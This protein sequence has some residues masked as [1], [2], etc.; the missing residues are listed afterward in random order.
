MSRIT[1]LDPTS[2]SGYVRELLDGVQKGLGVTPNLFRTA[3]RS[4]ATLEGLVALFGAAGRGKLGAKYR[5]AIALTV[6]ELDRCDYCLSA[7]SALGRRAGLDDEAIARARE[8]TAADPRLAAAVRFAR[9]VA[10]KRGRVTDE[11]VTE[12]RRVGIG[13]DEILEIVTN[14]ALT[15]FTNYLNE[16]AMTEIDF[17]VVHH[18]PR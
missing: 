8:G 3:A 7:H 17:P 18:L 15:A 10:E 1:A 14:V 9:V 5:E 2:T 13:D 16:V 11:D 6:S 4:P 12:V